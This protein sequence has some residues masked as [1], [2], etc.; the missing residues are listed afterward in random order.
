[1]TPARS[2]T[3]RARPLLVLAAVGVLA[4]CAVAEAS[5]RAPSELTAETV[6]ATSSPTSQPAP[7]PA[8]SALP[9]EHVGPRMKVALRSAATWEGKATY[10][11]AHQAGTADVTVTRSGA[12][13]RLD[14]ATAA[15]TSVLM[16]A[17]AGTVACQVTD[18]KTCVLAAAPGAP[19]PPAFDAGLATLMFTT[20]PGLLQ[21]ASGLV[22][23][24]W[25]SA[26]SD[27]ADKPLAAAACA[28][29]VSPTDVS[30]YCVTEAGLLV[31]ATLPAGT[32]TLVTSS[33][34]VDPAAF[35]PPA[36]P[37]PLA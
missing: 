35:T 29:V 33:P 2:R 25:L 15:G 3:R 18:R 4:A 32:L 19:L 17:D 8:P 36:T 14:V 12:K 31:R 20:L 7:E 6:A 28:E 13:W 37:V 11:L 30:Q 16:T 23:G 34:D 24:G 1:M 22:D 21:P 26:G 9:T 5:T 27:G 10:K